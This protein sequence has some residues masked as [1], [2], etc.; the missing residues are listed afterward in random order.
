VAGRDCARAAE[1]MKSRMARRYWVLL[2]IVAVIAVVFTLPTLFR[3]AARGMTVNEYVLK[4]GFPTATISEVVP[5][6]S[7]KLEGL[8]LYGVVP[9]S[10][11]NWST[12]P[13]NSILV[14]ASSDIAKQHFR[15]FPRV[16]KEETILKDM[17]YSRRS[18]FFQEWLTF[19]ELDAAGKVSRVYT[20]DYDYF[21]L[22][23]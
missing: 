17:R 5:A 10:S 3:H 2:A 9:Y 16:M 13:T 23:P 4:H 20:R 6:Q 18:I 1:V 15:N 7:L 21:Y 11:T 8:R 22:A 12:S 14:Y 19:V